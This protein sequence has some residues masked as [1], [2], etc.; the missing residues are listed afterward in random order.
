MKKLFWMLY[1]KIEASLFFTLSRKIAGNIGFLFLFQLAA[2]YLL[3]LYAQPENESNETL[4]VAS[5]ALLI[6][7]F[8]SFAFT[9]FYLRYLIVRPVKALV[10]TLNDINHTRGDLSTRLPAFTRDEFRDLSDA[11]NTFTE[12][13]MVLLSQ[14]YGQAE[15]AS[16]ANQKVATYVDHAHTKVLSQKDLSNQIFSSSEQVA[17]R[18]GLVAESTEKVAGNIQENLEKAN[19]AQVGI[20]SS[21]EQVE[22]IDRLLQQF[23]STV[24]GLESNA[25]NISNILKMVEE[26]ADQTN[27]L[28]LN[29]AIEAARAGEHGRGFA[30][31]ADEVRSLSTKVADA[32][33]QITSFIS[34]MRKLVEET[35]NESKNLLTETGQMKENLV[36]TGNTFTQMMG[37]FQSNTA[38]FS[39]I[40]QSVSALNELYQQ[41]HLALEDIAQM[42]D[43]VQKEMKVAD[44]EAHTAQ[45]QALATK[46]QLARFVQS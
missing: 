13:L 25:T 9:I 32:T 41:T 16:S 45:Q 20:V 8:L 43:A 7:S 26:F 10:G 3:Y 34:A 21:S 29:A 36:G 11:Y 30:V 12:N 14:V 4:F 18:I 6:V 44:D 27:L 17:Q 24:E 22:N 5:I 39:K 46:E 37:D 23:A 1:E 31:V 40:M 42:G 38:E 35:K 28:A 33:K 2:F 15:Q 19:V